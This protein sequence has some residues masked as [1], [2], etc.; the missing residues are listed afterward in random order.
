[1]WGFISTEAVYQCNFN[2]GF[3]TT[4]SDVL[5]HLAQ[6]QYWW[7]F[8]FA[9]LWSFYYIFATKTV[10]YRALKMRPKI[11]TSYRPHGKWGD[12]LAAII[13]FIWCLNILTNS[14]FILRLIEWQN[15]SSLFTVRVRARQWYWIY[16][17]ELK[18]FT[19]I[20]TAPK[21]V[22]TNRW[23]VNTFGDLQTADDYL[24]I[25]Q[26][27]SQNKWI[28]GYWTNVLNKTGK[29][30]QA[31]IVS[32]HEQL[33]LDLKNQETQNSI[34]DLFNLKTPQINTIN[35]LDDLFT[36]NI[37]AK[38]RLFSGDLFNYNSYLKTKKSI[39]DVK[40][41]NELGS[42]FSK[43]LVKDYTNVYFLNY[44][45]SRYK[46]YNLVSKNILNSILLNNNT[47]DTLINTA[48]MY[49][50]FTE[51]SRI[52][53]RTQG[54]LLPIRIIKYPFGVEFNDTDTAR[55]ETNHSLDLFRLRF[56]DGESKISHKVI[57]HTT[58]LT[59]KQKRYKRKKVIPSQIKYY[60]DASGNKTKRVRYSG[61]PILFNNS[62]FEDNISDPTV[63]Y[64]MVKKNKK[65]SELI[66]VTLAKRILRVKRTLVLPAH[67]N[68]TLITNSYDIVHSWFIPGL[69]VK[70]DCV[71]GRSTH[72]TFYID[73]VGF[74]YGQCAEICGRYHHHMPIRV[75]ALPFEHF[76]VWWH[77]FGLP[78]LLFTTAQ[79]RYETYYS[80]RKY[81]W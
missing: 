58:Y 47:E 24:H 4:R 33:R 32:P 46:K 7:W 57:P 39:W 16:K 35:N 25:L 73:S 45:G 28:K 1:M 20:L 18:N 59:L 60:Q 69:G 21:N 64:R 78:K 17:F 11:V 50:D 51:S 30:K 54:V 38:K 66:P 13:P 53:K 22:G 5:V 55:L 12:F 71:P 70:L 9:F 29:V 44:F 14:N 27:R 77:S 62:I 76:L 19:D 23:Q 72:H 34:S 74:Y 3:S 56:N 65:R 81:V 61:K 63:L 42:L 36:L 8:W 48:N 40:N 31:H 37:T 10:R 2:N 49:S 79:K 68:I 15:E 26:L 75:C 6:W 80:F 52:V 43:D 41:V 67:V